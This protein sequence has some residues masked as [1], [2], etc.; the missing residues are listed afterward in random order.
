MEAKSCAAAAKTAPSNSFG[1]S[2][3]GRLAFPTT[4]KG[5]RPAEEYPAVK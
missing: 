2:P 3:I 5:L 4:I 1:R